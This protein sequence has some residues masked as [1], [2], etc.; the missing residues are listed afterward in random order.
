[1]LYGCPDITIFTDHKNDTFSTIH[2]QRVLQW[3]LFLE[4]FGMKLSYIKGETNHLADTLSCLPFK[5]YDQ[6][7]FS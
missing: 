5:D 4:D 2:T 7:T 6:S 3:H 1:M